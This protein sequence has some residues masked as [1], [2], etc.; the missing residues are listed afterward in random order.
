MNGNS[1]SGYTSVAKDTGSE[2]SPVSSGF[3]VLP[4]FGKVRASQQRLQSDPSLKSSDLYLD[5]AKP[6]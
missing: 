2:M 5:P 6:G 4:I 1:G 3:L